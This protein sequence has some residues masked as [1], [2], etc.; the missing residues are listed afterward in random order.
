MVAKATARWD[1]VN[2]DA[3]DGRDRTGG[4]KQD[5]SGN[6]DGKHR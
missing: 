6:N 1:G 3:K 5:A 2:G 4:G